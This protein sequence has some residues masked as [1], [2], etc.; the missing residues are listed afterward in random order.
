MTTYTS[1]IEFE[2]GE[3]YII[4]PAEAVA[5]LGWK[6]G[7]KLLWADNEDGTYSL[8]KVIEDEIL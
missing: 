4:F 3:A 6:F 1:S 5:E 8:T 2:D 7:D